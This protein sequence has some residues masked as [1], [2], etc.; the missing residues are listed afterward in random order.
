MKLVVTLLV[1]L[2]TSAAA[3]AQDFPAKPV[4]ILVSFPPGGAT[5]LTARVLAQGLQELWGQNVIVENRGGSGGIA[6]T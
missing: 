6:A 3:F 4:R 5:D 2:A 1:A